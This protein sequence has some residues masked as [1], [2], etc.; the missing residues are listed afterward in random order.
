[1]I[2]IFKNTEKNQHIWRFL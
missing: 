1:L 2:V